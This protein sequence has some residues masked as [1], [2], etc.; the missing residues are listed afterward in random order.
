MADEWV[1]IA[2]PNTTESLI[3]KHFP[4]D[5]ADT[6]IKVAQ[7]ESSFNSTASNM[8]KNGTKDHGLFQIND[9]NIPKLKT[10]KVI[11][12]PEDLYDPATNVKAAAFLYNQKGF[13]PWNSSKSKWGAS[14]PKDE[15][16]DVEPTKTIPT[17]TPK[18]PSSLKQTISSI[19]HPTLQALGMAGGAI[20][21]LPLAPET[22]GLS[23]VAGAGLGY[24]GAEQVA[25]KLDE[26]MGIRKPQPLVPELKQAGLDIKTGVEA[27]MLGQIGG[28]V[29]SGVAGKLQ[30]MA[31]RMYGR[32]AKFSTTINPIERARRITTALEEKLPLTQ[33]GLEKSKGIISEL[34]NRITAQVAAH[35]EVP[36]SMRG[37]ANAAEQ[38]MESR[39]MKQTA[40]FYQEPMAEAMD[41][42][43]RF[44]EGTQVYPETLA[45]AQQYKV[46]INR[47]LDSFYQTLQ[48]SPLN[49]TQ[50]SKLW[51][52]KTKA[53]IGDQL[54]STIYDLVPELR[55]MNQREGSLIQLN[56]SLERA[57]NRI[58]NRDFIAFF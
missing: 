29:I 7:A 14:Q 19:A 56:K 58:T 43:G 11:S 4:K 44:R 51:G 37:I 28:K 16:V 15:W 45:Q 27:E 2:D 21:G 53:A 10:A 39:I 57:V 23:S 25:N 50:L 47:E 3:R 9:V 52:A 31:Q 24:A 20:A 55:Q 12:S 5:A 6:A 30:P 13:Q 17:P 49:V 1:D 36:V 22:L 34:N 48:R 40:P 18:Q 35:S 26:L 38:T 41:V 42:L 32:V 33:K 46:N 54:R 8:N